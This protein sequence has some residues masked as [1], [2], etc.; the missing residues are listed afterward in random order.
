MSRDE[1]AVMRLVGASALLFAGH[2]YCRRD[3]R[4]YFGH[5]D[6]H[7]FLPDYSLA[8]QHHAVFFLLV[9]TCFIITPQLRQI[10]LIIVGSGV[11]IGSISSYLA[12]KNILKSD[13][14]KDKKVKQHKY[15]FVVGGVMSGV[16][17]GVATSSI[18]KILQSKGL[19]G[20][21]N[22]G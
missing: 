14:G 15:I 13:Y 20:Q 7:T 3:L 2:F 21:P 6:P 4:I 1:I 16:G 18:G 11:A 19:Q 5:T 17:K 9:L 10:F 8:R 22:K 12:V